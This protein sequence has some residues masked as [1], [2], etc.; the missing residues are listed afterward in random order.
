VAEAVAEAVVAKWQG[1]GFGRDRSAEAVAVAMVAI[2]LGQK[3]GCGGLSLI[4]CI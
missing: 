4:E 1:Q 3:C 2:W